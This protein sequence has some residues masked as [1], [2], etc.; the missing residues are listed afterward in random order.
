M[1]IVVREWTGAEA[2]ALRASRR[3]SLVDFAAHIGVDPSVISRWEGGGKNIRPRPINQQALDTI[4]ERLTEAELARFVATISPDTLS[5][6]RDLDVPEISTDQRHPSDG[7]R[8]VWV[9]EGIFL[10]G[11]RDEP[12]WVG[13]FWIDIFPTTNGDYAN[14]VAAAGHRPPRHW[15]GPVPPR[16]LA[17]HP[18][19]WIDHDDACAY[20]QWADKTLPSTQQW[21]KAARG[22]RGNTWPWGK[23]PT[24]AKANVR[25]SGPGRT[26]PVANYASGVSPYGVYDCVGNTWEWTSSDTS[27]GRFELK[28]GAFTSPFDRGEPASFNDASHTM[29]DDDTGFRCVTTSIAPPETAA[30]PAR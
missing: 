6:T 20:A 8:M 2:A 29:L 23:Q 3:M 15:N 26:T 1:A 22:T 5:E 14:F 24:P 18:V 21:E 4:L 11:P 12:V 25:G 13:G 30:S 28:G 27:T 10:S 16:E 19:V 9:P 17:E 7:K